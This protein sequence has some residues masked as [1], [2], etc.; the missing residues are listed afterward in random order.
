ME[1]GTGL[2]PDEGHSPG[3]PASVTCPASER[4]LQYLLL[5]SSPV[6]RSPFGRELSAA[7]SKCLRL[8]VA[9][10]F[11]GKLPSQ[12]TRLVPFSLLAFACRFHVPSGPFWGG[13]R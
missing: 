11:L 13:I 4:C 1:G 2:L 3:N 10:L 7:A 5:D 9:S 8:V 12:K 6:A